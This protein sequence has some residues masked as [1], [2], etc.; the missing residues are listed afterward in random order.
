MEPNVSVKRGAAEA[1][2]GALEQMLSE[3]AGA[4]DDGDVGWLRPL[5]VLSAEIE[6]ST[7]RSPRLDLI[8][9]A[10]ACREL[11]DLLTSAPRA[12]PEFASR[13]RIAR[14]ASATVAL[15]HDRTLAACH[16]LTLSSA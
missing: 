15:L 11:S 2:V 4:T 8:N 9:L 16:A 3:L 1:L 10:D 12:D 14:R 5:A 6:Y 7:V 13:Y